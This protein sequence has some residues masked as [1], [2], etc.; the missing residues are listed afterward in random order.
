[1]HV[2]RT[3][4][5]VAEIEYV[6]KMLAR[7]FKSGNVNFLVGSGASMPAIPIAGPV[8]TAVTDLFNA[9]KDDAARAKLY[10][11][12]APIQ[13]ATNSLIAGIADANNEITLKRYQSFLS[14]VERI[15]F[16]RRQTLLPTQARVFSTNYDLFVEQASTNVPDLRLNDGFS[17][18]PSLK[19]RAE[20]APRTFFDLTSNTGNLYDYRVEVPCINLVKLHGSLSWKKDGEDV[21]FDVCERP[22]LPSDKSE[23]DIKQFVDGFAVVLPE[24]TKFRRMMERVYYELL[25]IYANE[26]DRANT[27]LLTFGFSFGDRHIFDITKHALKNPTLRLVIFGFDAAAVASYEAMF[28]GNNNVEIVSPPNGEQMAFDRFNEVLASFLPLQSNAP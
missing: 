18:V 3:I 24:A 7:S 11:F 4:D 17:R 20:Y 27:L 22:L 14:L 21:V 12:L 6:R 19:Q 9:N 5:C 25:R 8:E 15:L 13:R 23:A 1:V 10:D 26:L 16:E 2:A 28:A